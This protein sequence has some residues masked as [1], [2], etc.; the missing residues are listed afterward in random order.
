MTKATSELEDILSRI[1][2]GMPCY[3]EIPKPDEPLLRP[4]RPDEVVV[5]KSKSRRNAKVLEL[6]DREGWA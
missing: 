3:Q 2:A 5:P 4:M 6:T 1:V